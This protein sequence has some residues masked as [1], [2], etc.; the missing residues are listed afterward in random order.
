MNDSTPESRYADYAEARGVLLNAA[1]KRIPIASLSAQ[2]RALLLWRHNRVEPGSEAQLACVMDLG[3]FSPVGGHKPALQR[4]L[5][6]A[7]PPPPGSADAAMLDAFTRARFS[8]FRMGERHPRGGITLHDLCRGEDVW[9]MDAHL[10][11][12]AV[13]GMLVGARLAWPE[14]FAMTCGVLCPV[15]VRVLVHVMENRMP[16]DGP[17]AALIQPQPFEPL[18]DRLL[19]EAAAPARLAELGQ[20]PLLP[21]YTYRAAIDLGLFG[22]VP[23]R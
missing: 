21:A 1:A 15:D 5:G 2:A 18:V 10:E 22:P 11:A 16:S 13:P 6:A 19:E 20:D 17:V 7:I 4:V 8:I 3:V 12:N 9:V 23:G 14:D